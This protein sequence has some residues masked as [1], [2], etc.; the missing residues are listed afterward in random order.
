MTALITVPRQTW[1]VW[2]V[3][4]YAVWATL[5]YLGPGLALYLDHWIY[6][7]MM[8]FGATVAGATPMGG[9]AVAF[10]VLSLYFNIDA[11]TAKNF[12]LMIQSIGM[13]SASIIV[14]SRRPR[15]WIWYRNVMIYI[16][17]SF[18]SFMI[19]TAMYHTVSLTMIKLIYVC[20]ALS[21]ICNFWIT[22]RYG[23]AE[24]HELDGGRDWVLITVGCVLGGAAAAFFGNGADMLI[25]IVLS[26]FWHIREREGV[27]ISIVVMAAVS[28]LGTLTNL[29][30]FD[31]ITY[32]TYL[33]WLA[34]A[35]VVAVFA[36]L[37][38][39]ILHLIPVSVMLGAVLIL[40]ATNYVYFVATNP[41][42]TITA[43]LVLAGVTAILYAIDQSQ[44][45]MSYD[46]TGT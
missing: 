32:D 42:E 23:T 10:P 18:A 22:R 11:E 2:I 15:P 6:A 7:V 24:D 12:S 17:I 39:V 34:A 20:L 8:M 27:D 46:T 35:P 41:A 14:L 16:G 26:L 38:N 25:Y 40:C 36:P 28:I 21:F 29:W 45:V 31:S 33:M 1:V 37:G 5:M 13:T 19:A 44:K 3:A 43:L 4:F 30:V 9:G